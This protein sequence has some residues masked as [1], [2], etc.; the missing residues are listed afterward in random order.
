MHDLGCLIHKWLVFIFKIP[1]TSTFFLGEVEVVV[2][3]VVAIGDV[4]LL[5]PLP[6]LQSGIKVISSPIK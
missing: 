3:V 6:L 1:K 2:V 4:V 5:P